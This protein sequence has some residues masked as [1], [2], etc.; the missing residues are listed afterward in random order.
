MKN[1]CV[2]GDGAWGTAMATLLAHNGYQV[3]LW[4]HEAANAQT[5]ARTRMNERYLP[6]RSYLNALFLQ[7]LEDAVCDT[8]WVFEAIPV[9]YLR[10]VIL[11]AA[12][13]VTTDQIWV[14]LSKGIEQDTFLLPTQIIDDVV[15]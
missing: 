4:C 10:S 14:V 9:Q 1:V 15:R 13:C 5:I 3:K 11:E 7:S 6:G 2:L 12:P 8:R